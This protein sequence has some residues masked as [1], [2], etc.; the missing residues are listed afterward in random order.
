[1]RGTIPD[2]R[3]LHVLREAS[4]LLQRGDAVKADRLFASSLPWKA[5]QPDLLHLLGRARFMQNR[6]GEGED[7]LRQSLKIAPV[8]ANV[9]VNLGVMLRAQDKVTAA[10]DAFRAAIEIKSDFAD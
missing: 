10:A 8:Q 2:M 3:L 4:G 5:N 6:P 7:L 9:Q 1:M